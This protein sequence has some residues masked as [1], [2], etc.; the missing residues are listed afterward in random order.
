MDRKRNNYKFRGAVKNNHKIIKTRQMK[1]YNEELFL[2]DLASF[3]WRQL[4]TADL[5]I[6]E[7]VARWTNKLSS[8]IE[9]HAP[10]MVRRVS[11]KLCPWITSG[12]KNLQKTGDKLKIA[13]VKAKSELLM[14]AYRKVRN[15]VNSLNTRLKRQYFT[16]KI[17]S[18]EGNLK[19]TWATINKLIN[20]KSKTTSISAIKKG[21]SIITDPQGMADSINNFFCSIGEKLSKE[22]PDTGNAFLDSASDG[23][24][25]SERFTFSPLQPDH[26]LKAINKFKTSHSFGVDNISS[27]FLKVGMPILAPSLSEI[28]NLS[29]SKGLFPNDWKIARVAPIYK[30]GPTDVD[31]NYRPISVLPV[32]SRLFEKLICDQFYSFLNEHRRLFSKQSG[33]R[34]FHSVLTC[35]LGCTNDWYLNLDKGQYTSVTFIDLKKAFDTVDHQIL[36][37]KLCV[38]GV[39]G[40]ELNWFRSYLQ[41]RKQ[42]CKVNGHVSSME[43]IKY[44][45][46][47]GSCLGPLLF[48]IYINDLPL[49]LKFGEVNMY[50]DDTSISYSSDSV[51]NIN[52]SV[53]EDLDHLKNWL[54]G[55]KLS[56]NVAKTQSMLIGSRTRL[57]KIGM[58]ENPEPA[59]KIGE[60]PISMVKHTKYLG[61]QIDQHLL[62]DEHFSIITKKIARG[63]GMLKYSKKYLP[64]STIQRMCKSLVE[65]YFRYCLP[66]W[67]NCGTTALQKVQKLQN[68]AARIV[69]NSPYDASALPLIKQLGWLNI[70]Q[71]IEFETTKI[72]H[73]TLHNEVPEYLQ[74]LFTRVSD[75]CVRELRNS[76]LD[77]NLPL[78]KTSFGQKSFSFRG[79]KLWNKLGSEAKTTSSFSA[80][81]KAV[82]Q[83]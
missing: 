63:L 42:C 13:A 53:N 54:E 49:S 78:L 44:G 75:K 40:K 29:M 25:E 65:P 52:D 45:V 32:V 3:D 82:T 77:L 11:E 23:S 50:A 2:M 61:V 19:E 20:K 6:D 35:L 58:S 5:D 59:L 48:L 70:Q 56:L 66:V 41:N 69:T 18:C 39:A 83:N 60:E 43:S 38:Y 30:D 64:L 24:T 67:G 55:N 1:N 9:K 51:T 14:Q 33:F 73:K 21:D 37:R 28:F 36:I 17:D 34:K 15:K 71:M 12:L 76:K 57:K 62:W 81:K 26:L 72:V 31:S 22:I 79:A 68:R 4:I 46:P 74:G 47:Q 8:I 10:L 7:I 80:F 16:N 27:Y